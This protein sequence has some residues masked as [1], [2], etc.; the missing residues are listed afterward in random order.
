MCQSDCG[1][2]TRGK[3]GREDQN[4]VGREEEFGGKRGRGERGERRGKGTDPLVCETERGRRKE[5]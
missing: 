1:V 3:R 4:R 2:W 5:G